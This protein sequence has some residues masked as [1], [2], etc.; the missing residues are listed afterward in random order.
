M[1]RKLII[2]IT[3]LI[4]LLGPVSITITYGQKADKKIEI[5]GVYGDPAPF[6]E[7][8]HKLEELGVNSIFVHSG[9]ITHDMMRMAK[10]AKLKVFA[11]FATLNGKNYVESYPEAWAINEK[12][13]KVK[14]AS[15]FM[16]VCP[17]EPGFQKYRMALLSKLLLDYELDGVWL[18]YVHWHA[19]F[20][21]PDPIL[22]ETCFSDSCL[23]S[24]SND[25]RI[26]IPEGTTAQKA[27]WILGNKEKQWRE[28]RC[29]VLYSWVRKMKVIVEKLRPGALLGLY[30]CPWTDVEFDGARRR[31]LGLDFELLKSTV[32]VFSPMVYHERMGRK[33]AWVAE[34]ISWLSDRLQIQPDSFPKI[35]PIVQAYDGSGKVSAKD[36]KTVLHGGL[37]GKSTGIMMFTTRA[38]A[39]NEAK[40][41]VMGKLYRAITSS[42]ASD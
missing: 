20:E 30:H 28:W 26:M 25:T 13:E 1:A 15:W 11:E 22:P 17:T 5:T 12:G 27:A 32:D 24:F 19:Q 33:P 2:Y 38:V 16:G 42:R 7:K 18:D 21:E 9:S 40:T 29:E 39:E 6:W 34:N 37:S 41:K 31:I 23:E 35:W 10:A 36:F 8:G 4:T 14:A 3:T